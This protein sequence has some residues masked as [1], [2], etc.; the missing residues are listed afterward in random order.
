[1]AFHDAPYTVSISMAPPCPPPIHSVAMPR[2]V[3]S[4]FIALTRCRTMRLP[5]QPTGWPRLIA[6]PSTFSLA[7]SSLPRGAIKPQD[8]AAELFVVPGR[9]ASQHL[10][11]EGLVQFPGLDVL[12]RQFVALQQLG[13]RH[14]R[15]QPHDRG[16]ERRPL[17]VDDHGFRRQAMFGDSRLRGENDPARA[18]GDLRGIAGRHLPPRPFEYRLERGEFFGRGIR[19]HAVIVIVEFAVARKRGLDLAL[20]GSRS[21]AHAPIAG[22]FRQH[23]R[24]TARA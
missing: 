1:M 20:R 3:P 13:R 7:R 15:P 6:P 19:P 17:A 8:L 14:H 16:I 2:L 5:L 24:P 11:R 4:R 23:R 10:R 12:K 21:P 22:G 9:Q 18:V